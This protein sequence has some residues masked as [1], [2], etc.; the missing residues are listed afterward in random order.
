MIVGLFPELLT[1]GG[2]QRAGR[3]VAAILARYA[4]EQGW[5][6]QF[7]SLNDPNGRGAFFLS[8]TE[9][10]FKGYG[11][12]KAGFVSDA[13]GMATGSTVLVVALHPNLAP[14]SAAME[15][16]ASAIRSLIF[17]HG[18]EVWTPL[19][20][21]RR[22]SLVRADR[23]AAPSNDTLNYL[24]TQQG[25]PRARMIRL[26]WALDPDWEGRLP[27]AT[28]FSLPARFPSGRVILSV[29]RWSASERYKGLDHL[30]SVL[31]RL[32]VSAP[33]LWLVAIG[34]GDDRP[35]LEA[36]AGEKGVA[37]RVRFLPSVTQDELMSCF[38]HCTLFAL[39][40]RSEGFGLV[41]LEAMALGKPVVGGAHGG[42]P[43]VIEDG[44]SG[45]LVRHGDLGALQNALEFLLG[46]PTR[47]TEMGKNGLARVQQEYRF[48][49][50][51]AR[52]NQL[53][54][55]VMAI[56]PL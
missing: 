10:P 19:N 32:I 41:F 5:E 11:R 29:G 6:S 49:T 16:R 21:I 7:L 43:E 44:K 40:S 31:P 24:A 27:C 55:E 53:L 23:I 18:V 26:P 12:R 20:W 48:S 54:D 52:L 14:I 30:I 22:R 50:F 39:P 8:G 4:D 33:D 1:A 46:N 2:V 15:W 28:Q 37:N 13:I 42:T 38:A 25:A 47:A 36:L 35:R 17:A 51:A 9:Y 45:L 56:I 3:H 34:D